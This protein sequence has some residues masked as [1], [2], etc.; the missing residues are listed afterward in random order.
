MGECVGFGDGDGGEI[1]YGHENLMRDIRSA[2]GGNDE[3]VSRIVDLLEVIVYR[4]VKADI[5]R[6]QLYNAV[7]TEGRIRRMAT[8]HSGL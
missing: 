1:V 2:V 5:G 7:A 6:D 8:G 3:L 4:G